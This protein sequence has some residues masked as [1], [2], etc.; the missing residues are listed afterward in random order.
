[1]TVSTNEHQ[2]AD[3]AAGV[4]RQATAGRRDVQGQR[5]RFRQRLHRHV[6]INDDFYR[7]SHCMH[8]VRL[9]YSCIVSQRLNIYQQTF[10]ITW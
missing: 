8:S 7:T 6:S 4:S 10:S 3:S 1:M 5:Q 2:A 9:L